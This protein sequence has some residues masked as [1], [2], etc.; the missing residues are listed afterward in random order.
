MFAYAF[1]LILLLPVAF[2]SS[3]VEG[4]FSIEQLTE[5][6]IRLEDEQFVLDAMPSCDDQSTRERTR[7]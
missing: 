4:L 5:M 7:E 3:T 6:G 2:L 1:L